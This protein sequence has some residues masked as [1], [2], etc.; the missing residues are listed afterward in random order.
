MALPF[1]AWPPSGGTARSIGLVPF[2]T[3]AVAADWSK[4]VLWPFNGNTFTAP[5]VL[6]TGA[7]GLSD[8]APDAAS[9]VW[10]VSAAG[11][12]W[13]QPSSGAAIATP[14]PAGSVY[15]GCAYAGGQ[16][17]VMTAL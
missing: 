7:F 1:F 4:P 15:T 11:T 10:T 9:G 12:L 3:G 13:Y 14:L 6:A 2:S 8:I 5:I 16:P 17:Y